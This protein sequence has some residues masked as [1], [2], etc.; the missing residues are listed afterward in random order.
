MAIVELVKPLQ[1]ISAALG[2]AVERDAFVSVDLYEPP[3][4]VCVRPSEPEAEPLLGLPVVTE[5]ERTLSRL[6]ELA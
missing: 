4:A 6:A 3:I 5:Q 1:Q 2:L